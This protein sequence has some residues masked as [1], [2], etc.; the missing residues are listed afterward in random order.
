[1]SDDDALGP[2]ERLHP[3]FLITGLGGSLRRAGGAFA[4]LAYFTVSGQ[5]QTLAIIAPVLALTLVAGLFLYWRFFQFRVGPSEIRID[6]GILNRTHRSIPFDRIQDVDITQPLLA[7][8]FGLARVKFET[9]GSAGAR[10]DEGVL[11]AISLERAQELR[12]LVRARRG[13]ISDAPAPEAVERPPIYAMDARRVLLAGIFNFSL[14]V[15]AGLFGLSQTFGDVAG[16]DPLSRRFWRGMLAAGSPLLDLILAHRLISAIAGLVVLVFVGLATGMVRT[17]LR[18]HGFRLDRSGVGLRRRRGLLTLT[19]VTL[20]IRRIQAAIVGTGPLREAFGWREL[21]LQ[22]LAR[23]DATK[24]DHIVAPLADEAEVATVIAELGWRPVASDIHWT[25]VSTAYAW[26]F[27][28]A[29][30]LL[31]I[32][33]SIQ[34]AIFPLVGAAAFVAIAVLI[35]FRWLAWRRTGYAL[36]GDRL[37]VRRGWWRRQ[38]VILPLASI[39]SA[40]LTENFISRRFGTASLLIGVAGGSGFSAHGVPALPRQVADSLRTLLLL[41]F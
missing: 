26:T 41:R 16:F 24:G 29:M 34:L 31:I 14:A 21:K 23:D 37:L 30:L 28:L 7:R 40:D 3:L 18:E 15:L 8:A 19:D 5:W 1:M 10:E 22:S 39:Q 4:V 17:L 6:S 20:P 25:R 27:T 2:A 35:A 32:P 11:Q 33:A 13:V 38:T 9:G 12:A 36:D